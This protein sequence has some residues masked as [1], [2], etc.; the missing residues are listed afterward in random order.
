MVAGANGSGK[1]TLL[2]ALH[3]LR[4][5]DL[6]SA[7]ADA[8]C[9]FVYQDAQ[10][11]LLL[12]NVATN[13][14][15][16]VPETDARHEGHGRADERSVRAA[17]LRALDDVGFRPPDPWMGKRARDLSGGEKQRVAIAAALVM[18][19]RSI[20]FDEVTASMDAANRALLLD[21]IPAIVAERKIAALWYVP[22]PAPIPSAAKN[23]PRASSKAARRAPHR[24]I[25]LAL[26]PPP[27]AGSKSMQHQRRGSY[28]VAVKVKALPYLAVSIFFT[29]VHSLG[30]EGVD[31]LC[32]SR[33]LLTRPPPLPLST[34][35]RQGDP[36]AG[37]IESSRH[38]YFVRAV[39]PVR[40]ASRTA[41]RC[42]GANRPVFRAIALGTG[43]T[44]VSSSP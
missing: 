10:R 18:R 17:V 28:R 2:A 36:H 39:L 34:T 6:G 22:L 7:R 21:L 44:R 33:R 19:P 37:R 30:R 12:P 24:L 15:V 11:Q 40:P 13:V 31:R 5:P 43:S 3:G 20:L 41:S 38:D 14:A 32:A 42:P 26:R 35:D 16:S 8:P 23:S 25:R 27:V 4:L 1:S 9:A 29:H